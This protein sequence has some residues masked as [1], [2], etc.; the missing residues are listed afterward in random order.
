MTE[1]DYWASDPA[2]HE[3]I[4]T[5]AAQGQMLLAEPKR[6]RRTFS[7]YQ[8]KPLYESNHG[9]LPKLTIW[10]QYGTRTLAGYSI[11]TRPLSN[12]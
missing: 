10:L 5:A 1:E 11:T 6:A 9:S 4:E 2:F 3:I 12:G 7:D 8:I